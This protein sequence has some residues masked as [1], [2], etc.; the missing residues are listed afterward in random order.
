MKAVFLKYLL[1]SIGIW[2]N[3]L[4]ISYSWYNYPTEILYWQ[5]LARLS[6]RI[7]LI[8]FAVLFINESLKLFWPNRASQSPLLAE[9]IIFPAFAFHHLVHFYFL[10]T[11][12]L[13]SGAEIVVYRLLGGALAYFLI[14]IVAFLWVWRPKWVKKPLLILYLYYVWF[15]MFMTYLARL[16]GK[17]ANAGGAMQDYIFFASIVFI[18]LLGNLILLARKIL[19]KKEQVFNPEINHN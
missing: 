6:G 10:A 1:L 11:Y 16:Q 15:V 18:L 12:M 13:K 4:I 7:S 9:K 14:V 5:A 17:F 19:G 8:L 2:A 3:M